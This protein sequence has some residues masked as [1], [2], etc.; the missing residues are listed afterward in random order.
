MKKT[1]D[2]QRTSDDLEFA[3]MGIAAFIPGMQ[4]MMELMQRELDRMRAQL[5]AAQR[6]ELSEE[7]QD[8]PTV[9]DVVRQTRTV[10]AKLGRPRKAQARSGWP[11]D[12]LEREKEAARRHGVML[13]KRE[14]GEP[15][16]AKPRREAKL[17]PRDSNHPRHEAW[18]AKLRKAQKR[19]WKLRAANGH[20]AAVV[21]Q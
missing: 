11:D 7:A 21:I 6:G 18:L 16:A 2:E 3:K 4:R 5:D 9:R 15:P 10:R 12:P 19:A 14:A 13:A 20:A 17:H 8:G 1:D